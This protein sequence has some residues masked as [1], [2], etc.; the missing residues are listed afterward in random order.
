MDFHERRESGAALG[1]QFK[2]LHN[3]NVTNWRQRERFI[4]D[5]LAALGIGEDHPLRDV[6]KK[7]QQEVEATAE[8]H[9]KQLPDL[10][11]KMHGEMD[12]VAQGANEP[13][14]GGES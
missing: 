6:F 2:D 5:V 9:L 4:T 8:A 11:A 7:Y 12:Q 10:E 1:Q 3:N 14:K 13:I